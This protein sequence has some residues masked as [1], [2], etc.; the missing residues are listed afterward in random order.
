MNGP[1]GTMIPEI[2][3]SGTDSRFANLRQKLSARMHKD[4]ALDLIERVIVVGFFIVFANRMLSRLTALIVL[5]IEHNELILP[6]LEMNIGAILLVIS[7]S[8]SVALIVLRR[9]SPT[10]S[11]HP[12]D[13]ALSFA[14]VTAP[15]LTVPAPA[16][17]VIPSAAASAVMFAGLIVQ[18]AAKVMLWRS[19]GLVPANRGIKTGGVYRFVRHPMYAGYALTHAGFL[20]GFP[21][22]RNAL[23]YLVVLLIQ[24]ARIWREESLLDD[25]PDYRAYAALVR[26]RLLPGVF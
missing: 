9:R 12:L 2:H 18:I 6:A 16:S 15:L 23:L 8:L 14:A 20:V 3:P 11:S 5:Q 4:I 24:I 17:T 1:K 10:L 26:Y 25:D 19:F 22:Y 7:E 21:D 13:W